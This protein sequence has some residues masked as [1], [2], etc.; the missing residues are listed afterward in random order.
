M[1]ISQ[2]KK[3]HALLFS[4]RHIYSQDAS[5]KFIDSIGFVLQLLTFIFT[6]YRLSDI[7][8]YCRLH[9]IAYDVNLRH[10]IWGTSEVIKQL[11]T[12]FC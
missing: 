12:E 3:N 9:G 2:S 8:T 4:T 1:S 7:K 6:Y 10:S 5:F 11:V